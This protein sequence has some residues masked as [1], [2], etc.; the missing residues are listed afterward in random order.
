MLKEI[1][2]SQR[3]DKRYLAIFE[4]GK[5]THFGQ[6][7]GS[8]YIDHHDKDKREAYRKRHA[9]DLNTNDPYRAGY[10]SYWLLWGDEKDLI[11][12]MLSYN[13]KFFKKQKP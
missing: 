13:R 11:Q 8:T 7:G 1:K 10:L 2:E 12:A 9:K 4:N 3:K 6:K 5:K